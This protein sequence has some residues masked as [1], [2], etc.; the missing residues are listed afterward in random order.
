MDTKKNVSKL[1][2]EKSL[3][4]DLKNLKTFKNTTKNH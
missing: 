1:L 3:E 4:A 2:C